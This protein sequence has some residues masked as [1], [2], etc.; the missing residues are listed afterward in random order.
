MA[1]GAL[2]K[3][4]KLLENYSL[5]K[6]GIEYESKCGIIWLRQLMQ[7]DFS[8]HHLTVVSPFVPTAFLQI[9]N[10]NNSVYKRLLLKSDS[11]VP[12][13]FCQIFHSHVLR[14]TIINLFGV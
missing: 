8:E 14:N 10:F 5:P 7:V 11:H 9:F 6:L 4:G 13:N 3:P 1:G 2:I 12:E